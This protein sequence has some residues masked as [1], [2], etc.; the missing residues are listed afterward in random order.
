MRMHST[1]FKLKEL[2]LEV[3]HACNLHCA[4][5]SSLAVA[6]CSR[7]MAWDDFKRVL[8]EAEEMAVTE[9]AISGGEP[10]FWE[11]LTAAIAYAVKKRI[12]V[13]LYT[14]GIAQN[15]ESI[16]KSLKEAGL[17]KIIFSVFGSSSEHHEAVTLTAGSFEETLKAIGC[18]TTLGFDVEFHFVPMA[19]NF[20]ELR[21]VAKLALECGVR[22]V[23]V[24]RLVPQGRGAAYDDLKLSNAANQTLRQTIIDLRNEGYDIRVG[25]PYNIL[26]LKENPECCAGIDRITISPELNISPCDAFKQISPSMFGVSDEYSNLTHHRMMDCWLKSPYLQK[27]REYLT[28]PFA[29]KCSSCNVLESCL[30]GCV[31][32]KFYSHREL[33]K[34]PDP[35][36]LT[37]N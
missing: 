35:M 7:Q 11:H 29:E 1:P 14:T 13:V 18:C 16:F 33:V 25:S 20:M 22:R 21:P 4:H 9:I 3:T 17:T 27:V 36:C 10:L 24:L 5:C 32:Q 15:A 8:D 37:N 26:M 31:A 30:S 34:C 6:E 19:G 2:K 28:S 23:S 12:N